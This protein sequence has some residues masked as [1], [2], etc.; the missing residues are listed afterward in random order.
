M[1]FFEAHG[2]IPDEWRE[3]LVDVPSEDELRHVVEKSGLP[4][5]SFV[6]THEPIYLE[7][8]AG[9]SFTDDEWIRIMHEHPEL[10]N[11]PIIIME[12]TVI[13]GRSDEELNRIL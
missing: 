5:G 9:K 1:E 8:F 7:K 2:I 13:I 3:Y 12:N 11:R 4:V 6:R 10:I